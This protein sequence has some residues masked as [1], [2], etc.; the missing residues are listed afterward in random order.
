M[1]LG[2]EKAIEQCAGVPLV[3]EWDGAALT[4]SREN[5][6]NSAT[7]KLPI[8]SGVEPWSFQTKDHAGLFG[9]L[10]LAVKSKQAAVLS[11]W[12]F[13]LKVKVGELTGSL[14]PFS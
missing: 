4:L 8:E 11:P 1:I 10:S 12:K 3:I 5:D 13:G 2:A 9:C 7:F 14:A 6:V